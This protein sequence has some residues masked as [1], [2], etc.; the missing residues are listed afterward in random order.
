M[1][2]P[3]YLK[4]RPNHMPPDNGGKVLVLKP[5]PD[6][7]VPLDQLEVPIQRFLGGRQNGMNIEA[8]GE[9]LYG[10]SA[11][12]SPGNYRAQVGAWVRARTTGAASRNTWGPNLLRRG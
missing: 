1:G 2:R 3:T 6:S 10:R 7:E 11:S 5:R 4:Q 9:E 12:T 8:R